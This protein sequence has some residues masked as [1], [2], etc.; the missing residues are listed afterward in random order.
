MSQTSKRPDNSVRTS[1][2]EVSSWARV[3]LTPVVAKPEVIPTRPALNC[4]RDSA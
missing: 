2:A 1:T 4:S 3:Q